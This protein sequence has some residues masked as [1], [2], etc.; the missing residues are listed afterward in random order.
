MS[1]PRLDNE[2][3]ADLKQSSAKASTLSLILFSDKKLRTY[4][5]LLPSNCSTILSHSDGNLFFASI[6]IAVFL[7]EK[8]SLPK[9]LPIM[10]SSPNIS[11]RSS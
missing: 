2:L 3:Y 9:L 8:I 1:K 4:A 11:K 5:K 7:F 10:L 6:A